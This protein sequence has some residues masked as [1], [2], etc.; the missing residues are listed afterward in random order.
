MLN[1]HEGILCCS[2]KG[3]L[4]FVR[5]LKRAWYVSTANIAKLALVD[6]CDLRQRRSKKMQDILELVFFLNPRPLFTCAVGIQSVSQ[7]HK[8]Q[9]LSEWLCCEFCCELSKASRSLRI[10]ICLSEGIQHCRFLAA[11]VSLA[12]F[13]CFHLFVNGVR[14]LFLEA[15]QRPVK[16]AW[17]MPWGFYFHW[18]LQHAFVYC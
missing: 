11:L 1:C 13:L 12:F 15:E 16:I 5:C 18:W 8:S 7:P 2:L 9:F 10:R 14:L 6:V 17:W 3:L 4:G